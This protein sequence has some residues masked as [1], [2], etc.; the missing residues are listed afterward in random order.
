MTKTEFVKEVLS[1]MPPPPQYFSKNAMLNK[2]GYSDFET[3][4]KTGD[5]PLDPEA[6][7]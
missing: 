4:L 7:L 5:V 2:T 1:G 3:V 6:Y